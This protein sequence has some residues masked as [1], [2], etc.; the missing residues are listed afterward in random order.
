MVPR[1]GLFRLLKLTIRISCL[2]RLVSSLC[3]S[4][5]RALVANLSS[6]SQESNPSN[7]VVSNCRVWKFLLKVFGRLKEGAPRAMLKGAFG[8][9][10]A[11]NASAF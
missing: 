4:V 6:L 11:V 10:L 3:T 7:R 2:R 5:V 8:L 9:S 1:R